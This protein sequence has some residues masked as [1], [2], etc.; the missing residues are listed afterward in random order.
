MSGASDLPLVPLPPLASPA[1][2]E[3]LSVIDRRL[4]LVQLCDARQ[5][6]GRGF[7]LARAAALSITAGTAIAMIVLMSSG[8]RDATPALGVAALGWLTWYV[9]G[10]A[11]LS[12]AADFGS[13]DRREGID[14]LVL[15][16]GQ[17]LRALQ[18][19]RW[20]AAACRMAAL[21]G[22]PALLLGLLSAAAAP[23]WYA[24]GRRV[25]L[26][27]SSCGYAVLLAFVLATLARTSSRLFPSRGGWVL[28]A[29]LLGPHLA[30]ALDPAVPSVPA[31]FADLR[32]DLLSS[33]GAGIR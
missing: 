2:R 19:A 7:R 14:V 12:A 29:V 8:G 15:Q 13:R 16:R 11:A 33:S 32:S 25:M 4:A 21:I 18:R 31:F 28:L 30:H 17:S 20:L 22:L 1:Q 27:L 24:L 10:C 6:E 23:T 9:G 3:G 26:C 5:R